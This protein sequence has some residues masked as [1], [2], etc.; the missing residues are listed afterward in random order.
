[1]HDVHFNRC[2]LKVLQIAQELLQGGLLLP[3]RQGHLAAA[4]LVHG[5]VELVLLLLLPLEKQMVLMMRKRKRK[6]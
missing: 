5:A 6:R 2:E 4:A 3:L 1:M